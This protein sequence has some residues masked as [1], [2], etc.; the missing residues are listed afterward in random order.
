MTQHDDFGRYSCQIQ[1]DGFGISSQK[2]LK[3]AKVLIV[4]V[5]GLGCPAAL[6][7]TAAGIGT[8]GLADDDKVDVKNLHRQIL[9]KN[10]D[11]GRPKTTVAN[12][13]LLQQNPAINIVCHP[14]IVLENAMK[15]IEDYDIIVDCSDNFDTR[16][17]LND[18][19]VL[20]GKPLVYGAIYQYEGQVG[21]WNIKHGDT[22]SSNYRDLFSSVDD[23]NIPNCADGGVIPTVG[24]IIGC[25]QASEVIKYVTGIGELL[26]NKLLIFDTLSMQSYVV[27]LPN[28]SCVKIVSLGSDKAEVTTINAEDFINIQ[29]DK[30][31]YQIIDV[32]SKEEHESF[33]LGGTNIPLD[34]Y[35]KQRIK[36]DPSKS[37][38]FYCR[39]D[40]R[41]T[42]A[43]KKAIRDNSNAKILVL[44][45][46]VEGFRR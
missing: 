29:N 5:G 8:L 45:G 46:G 43:A 30:K 21:V 23:S 25:M 37:T 14:R 28:R 31:N 26:Q 44:S 6:Y 42:K 15:I 32:R 4:G 34:E 39:T 2:K 1:L 41:S 24:G 38:V 27:S 7:L 17:L 3:D 13:L 11:I 20:S 33:N 40:A 10:N 36:L 18:A 9:Y 35:M 22:F 16:Y 12:E 19:C